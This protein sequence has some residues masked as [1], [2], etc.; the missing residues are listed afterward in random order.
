[1]LKSKPTTAR[2]YTMPLAQMMHLNRN[3]A[4]GENA[5]TTNPPPSIKA[6]RVPYRWIGPRIGFCDSRYM[7]EHF[8]VTA[9]CFLQF[10]SQPVVVGV[11]ARHMLRVGI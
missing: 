10:L 2:P 11:L 8:A 9:F 4:S 1:M 6:T 3:G 5:A 7:V